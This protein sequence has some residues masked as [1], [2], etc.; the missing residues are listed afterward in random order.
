MLP[1]S[2]YIH[3][4]WCIKKCPYCDFNSHKSPDTIP[5][6][7]YIDAL[8]ADFENDL[9][10]VDQRTLHSIFIGGGTPSLLSASAF[11][12]LFNGIQQRLPF[13]ED[14]EITLEANPG[15]VEQQRFTD[16]R[17]LGINRLSLGVQSFNAHHLKALGRIHDDQQAHRAIDSARHAGFNNINIDIM[18][19]LPKQSVSEGLADLRAAIAHEP[20]H[21][22]WYQL[23][24]EP[25]T[26]FYKQRPTL[27][28]EDEACTLEEKGLTL[29]AKKGFERYEI[30]AF[31]KQNKR[32]QHNMNYWLFG[33]YIGIG[34]G[35]HGKLTRAPMDVMRTRKYRQPTDYLNITKPFLASTEQV[36]N[37]DL[38]FEFMLNTTRLQEAIPNAL[39]TERTGLAFKT[40]EPRLLVAKNKG[41]ITL[42]NHHWQVTCLGRR[43]TN[44]LQALFLAE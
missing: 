3:I 12:R 15:T 9:L 14:I 44:D 34:A 23:T 10:H 7:S 1:L 29:L 6:T 36:S 30:S 21:L 31:S 19:G 37:T 16:Y 25:N 13:K 28:N 11:E 22:S 27:P 38:L 43:Y 8:L 41:L 33:D 39:F 42:N 35:A 32:S 18:H 40:L 2:L 24:I 4:P 17:A 20:E 26:L 5:E